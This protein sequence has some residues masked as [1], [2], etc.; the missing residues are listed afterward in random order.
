MGLGDEIGLQML[1]IRTL[2]R[3]RNIDPSFQALQL[4]SFAG[5]G[6]GISLE[7]TSRLRQRL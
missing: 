2:D 3:S 1:W 5:M 4:W 6:Q 7:S